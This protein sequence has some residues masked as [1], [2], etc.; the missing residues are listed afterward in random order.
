VPSPA[1][2]PV[3]CRFHTRCPRAADIGPEVEPQ[4]VNYGNDHWAAC[5]HPVG[6]DQP[7]NLAGT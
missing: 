2:P 6:R 4:L 7:A 1:Y 3:A 5:H